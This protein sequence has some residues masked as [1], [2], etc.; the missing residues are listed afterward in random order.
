MNLHQRGTKVVSQHVCCVYELLPE[1]LKSYHWILI[2]VRGKYLEFYMDSWGFFEDLDSLYVS[3]V[4][5]E[6]VRN[7]FRELSMTVL[8][9]ELID[10]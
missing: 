7:Y 1:G 9:I 4:D 5:F 8:L 10:R 2:V 3:R 6:H